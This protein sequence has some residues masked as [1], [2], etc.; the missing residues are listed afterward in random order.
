[1]NGKTLSTILR[2]AGLC[3]LP[4]PDDLKSLDMPALIL[5]WEGDKSHPVE[6][7]EILDQMMPQST[8][9]IARDIFDFKTWPRL[10]RDFAADVLD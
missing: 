1:M 4:Q 3:D 2:G 10:M 9:H 5:A 7:A 8:L 6:T